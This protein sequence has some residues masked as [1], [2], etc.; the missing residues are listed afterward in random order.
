[1][2]LKG[3]RMSDTPAPNT[4]PG[5]SAAESEKMQAAFTNIAERSQK[6]LAEFAERSQADGPQPADPLKLTQTF[7]DFTAK[8]LDDPTRMVQAQM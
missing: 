5:L 4:L 1:M 8:M 6:L 7:M 2:I 3:K